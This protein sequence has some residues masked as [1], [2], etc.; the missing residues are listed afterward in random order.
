MATRSGFILDELLYIQQ[1]LAASWQDP[2]Q[3]G[4]SFSA[5]VVNYNIPEDTVERINFLLQLIQFPRR[6]I[7]VLGQLDALF[8]GTQYGNTACGRIHCFC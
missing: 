3:A 7:K 4:V 1:T 8:Q 2:I 6:I 5:L